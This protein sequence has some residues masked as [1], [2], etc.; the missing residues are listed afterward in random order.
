MKKNKTKKRKNQRRGPPPA[1]AQ[2]PPR[3]PDKG[4]IVRPVDTALGAPLA[5]ERARLTQAA[6]DFS[7]SALAPATRKAYAED[8]G[9][10]QVWCERHRL[11]ALPAGPQTVC[12]YLTALATNDNDAG[13]PRTVSTIRR[14]MA[15]IS[16]WHE[17]SGLADPFDHPSIAPV[18]AGIRRTLGVAPT[19]IAEALVLDDVNR[20][21][22][23]LKDNLRDVRDRAAL[24]LG[25]HGANRRSEV[26]EMELSWLT[27]G[28]RGMIVTF[29]FSKTNQ[30]GELEQIAIPK[31]DDPAVCPVEATR[32][33]LRVAGMGPG[34][35][36]RQIT[37]HGNLSL[38]PLSGFGYSRIIKRLVT[39]IGLDPAGY[40]GHSVRRGYVTTA[41]RAGETDA[42]IMERTRHKTTAMVHRYTAPDDLLVKIGK[43]ETW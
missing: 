27:L 33:W 30:E 5:E 38:K 42:R 8:A 15:A 34:P 14:R 32:E 24:L 4:I 7:R 26:T 40:S 29:P 3:V 28:E 13:R 6:V 41:H 23:V 21:A 1:P 9:R 31:A 43:R 12:L 18:W 10:F 16:K 11:V 2:R 25:F 22:R 17:L 19:D 39:L 35:I 36:L 20:I 37:N